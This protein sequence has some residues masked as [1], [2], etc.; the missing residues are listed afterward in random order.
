MDRKQLTSVLI[1]VVIILGLFFYFHDAQAPAPSDMAP[2]TI[3]TATT[4]PANTQT[5][6]SKTPVNKT[7][8]SNAVTIT[9]KNGVFTPSILTIKAGK[10][11]LFVNAS[12]KSMWV[13]SGTDVYHQ[14]YPAFNQ[15]RAVGKGG[16]YSFTF[17]VPGTYHFNNK[18]TPTAQGTI[19]VLK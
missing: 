18:I 1:I 2:V 13:D 9:Y 11:V 14:E 5:D 17:T 10:S 19:T 6:T 8:Q 12:D 4:V 3:E 15:E 16:T 7:T